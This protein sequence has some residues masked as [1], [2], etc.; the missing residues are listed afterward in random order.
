M[1][2]VGLLFKGSFPKQSRKY[3]EDFKVFAERGADV[4]D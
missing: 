1:K 3:L 2:V 4:R